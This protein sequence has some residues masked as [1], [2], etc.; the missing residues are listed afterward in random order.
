MMSSKKLEI[1][2]E[3]LHL[4][5]LCVVRNLVSINQ[6]KSWLQRTC[7]ADTMRE[8]SRLVFTVGVNPVPLCHFMLAY[9]VLHMAVKEF[10]N[11]PL[12]IQK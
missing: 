3:Y 4:F 11:P 6:T 5:F 1:S 9:V 8:N 10:C 12:K 7:E 2:C